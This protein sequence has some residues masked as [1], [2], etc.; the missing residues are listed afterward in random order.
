MQD[1]TR[2][3]SGRR[4]ALLGLLLLL[5]ALL[6]GCQAT[7]PVTALPADPAAPER[8]AQTPDILPADEEATPEQRDITLYYRMQGENMLAGETRALSFPK[9]KQVERVLVEA[10]IAGP[11][12]S[13]LDLTGVFTPGTKVLKVWSSGDLLTVILTHEFLQPPTGAPALWETD[14]SWRAEIYTRRQQ[15]L[16]SIVNTITEATSY[17]SVQIMVLDRNDDVNGRRL[18]RSELYDGASGSELLGPMRRSESNLLTHFNTANILMESW[19]EQT[20]DR[21]YR[22]VAQEATA[23]PTDMSFQQEMQ[24]LARRLV[25]FDISA[26]TVAEDGQTALLETSYAYMMDGTTVQVQSFP[27]HL[28]RENGLWK[29]TYAE[30]RRMMEAI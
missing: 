22:F 6:A 24:A 10:L 16:A 23:R 18:R 25:Y 27:L 15:A 3:S 12:P 30:L 5:M 29:I 8:E 19:K 14:D 26:G 21:L 1:N 2:G 11:S 7:P 20:F 4:W 9:D 17:T 13:L 28:V